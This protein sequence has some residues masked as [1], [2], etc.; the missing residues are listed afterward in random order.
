MPDCIPGQVAAAIAE[1]ADLLDASGAGWVLGG[2][3][4]LALRGIALPSPPRDVD[5]YV[6]PE[7]AAAAHRALAAYAVDEQQTSETDI[8]RSILSHYV[9]GGV[10]LELVGGFVVRAKNC[11]YRTEV[12]GVLLPCAWR[13]ELD[14]RRVP[15]APLA[16][17][18]WFN[19][20]REREDRTLLVA[21]AMRGRLS[22]HDAA[23]REI[24][25]R[26][27]LDASVM[28]AVH[29]RIGAGAQRKETRGDER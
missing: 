6:D 29:A 26:N 24:E 1:A 22:A 10:Q 15:V 5:L 11:E 19:T 7:E 21:A 8:Y 28:E 3:A 12:R 13:A 2:S 17:E 20:L 23:L 27:R 16:H 18:L 9:I 4:G 14:G 25:A